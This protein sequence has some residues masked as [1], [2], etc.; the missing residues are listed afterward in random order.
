MCPFWIFIGPKDDEGSV[1]NW[2]CKTCRAPVKS[3]PPIHKHSAFYRLDALPVAN[4]QRQSTEEK[5]YHISRTC[6]PPSLPGGPAS[7][8]WSLKASDHLGEGC[9]AFCQPSDT[10]SSPHYVAQMYV[11]FSAQIYVEFSLFYFVYSLSVHRV[12][13]HCW[14]FTDS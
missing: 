2:S 6:S 10:I 4:Q 1:D 8:S 9:Q 7:L 14:W 12:L 11:K 3:T 13:T 5:K